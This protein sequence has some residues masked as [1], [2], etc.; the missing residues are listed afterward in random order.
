M[1]F[2]WFQKAAIN[3]DVHS[4]YY[5]GYCYDR[6]NGVEKNQPNAFEWYLKVANKGAICTN[7][8]VLNQNLASIKC[9]NSN[10]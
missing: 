9:Q 2:H 4:Q 1:A 7:D 6:G 5:V 10:L 8:K 3:G